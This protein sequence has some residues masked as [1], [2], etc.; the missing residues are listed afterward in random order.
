MQLAALNPL[1]TPEAERSGAVETLTA[2][3]RVRLAFRDDLVAFGAPLGF[4]AEVLDAWIKTGL[5]QTATVTTDP[6]RATTA[7]V[8]APTVA[9]ARELAKVTGSAWKGL[10]TSRFRRSGRKL[11]H[12]AGV[13]RVALTVL[14]AHRLG[15][16]DLRAIGTDDREL[17]TSAVVQDAHGNATR[18]PL[19]PDG[20]ILAQ[21]EGRLRILLLENDRGTTSAVRLG[22]KFRAYA[23][24]QKQGGPERAFGV[25]ALRVMTV[26]PDARRE[27]RLRAVALEAVGRP[28]A[29][30]LFARLEDVTPREPERLQGPIARGLTGVA[31]PFLERG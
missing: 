23:D 25:K 7:E 8:V 3:V 16:V 9:G 20:L 27:E 1:F 26:V 31:E 5:V 19:Q 11:V 24:W 2:L 10:P 12:D 4:G 13:G 18:V 21:R 22:E 15:L 29:M 17:A 28:S 30:F 6:A 14:A